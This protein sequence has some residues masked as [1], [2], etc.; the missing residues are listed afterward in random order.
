MLVFLLKSN[1]PGAILEPWLFTNEVLVLLPKVTS[2]RVFGIQSSS[3]YP[4][5]DTS[6]IPIRR[7]FFKM[8]DQTGTVRI[9]RPYPK[10]VHDYPEKTSG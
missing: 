8:P 4:A 5:P 7:H 3:D 1:N 10:K 6:V 2:L 9:I